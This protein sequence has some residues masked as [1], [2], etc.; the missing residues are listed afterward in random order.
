M[1]HF[2]KER[3]PFFLYILNTHKVS[4]QDTSEQ[5]KA[6]QQTLAYRTLSKAA[7]DK[8]KS[9]GESNGMGREISSFE[10]LSLLIRIYRAQERYTELDEIF[11]DQRVGFNAYNGGIK[12]ELV[13]QY[14]ELLNLQQRWAQLREMCIAILKRCRDISFEDTTLSF[15][16][17]GNDWKIWQMLVSASAKHD[18]IT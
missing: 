15:G 5:Q 16:K 3:R 12:W 1:K 10:D 4:E 11:T 9:N 2:P 13:G 8:Q 18:P 6:L 14:M 17:L 7:A